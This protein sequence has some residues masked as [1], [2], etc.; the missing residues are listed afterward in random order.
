MTNIALDLSQRAAATVAP[1]ERQIV[2]AGPGSG[3]TEVVSHLV[4]HLVEDLGV[5][6]AEGLVVLSFSNAAVFAADARLRARRAGPVDVQTVDSLAGEILRDLADTETPQLSFDRRIA[7]ATKLLAECDWDRLEAIEHLVVDEIQD[8]V[9]VRADFLL[10]VLG[11]LPAGAGFTLLGDPA[12]GIYDFQI[13]PDAKPLSTTTSAALLRRAEALGDVTVRHLTGQYRATSRD[14]TRLVALREAVL[15]AD[16]TGELDDFAADLVPLGSIADA[17]ARARRWS[18]TTVF[19]TATNGQAM[20]VA[21]EITAAGAM[22]EVRRSARQRVHASWIARLLADRPTSGVTREELE[23]LVAE[24]AQELE[25]ASLWRA[26]RSVAR[27]RGREVDLRALSAGLRRPRPLMPD[28]IDRP[29]LPLVVS[30]V[31]RAKGLEFDHVVHVDFPDKAWVDDATDPQTALRTRYVALSR[32]RHHIVRASGPDD[33][34]LRRFELHGMTT[35]RWYTG[36]YKP[37]MTFSYEFRVDDLDRG[38][39]P[40]EDAAAVQCHIAER[41]R[42]G[43]ELTLVLD[44]ARSTLTMPVWSLLHEGVVV[45]RTSEAFGGDLVARIGTL[46]RKRRGWPGLS[47]ARVESVVTVAGDPQPA[48]GRHGLWLSPVSAGLLRI[49]WNGDTDG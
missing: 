7:L 41:V 45:G 24:R 42:P 30:T 34:F 32:A 6:A 8:V 3:K 10:L 29:N 2:I 20:M 35:P 5:D 13:R 48:T 9:G 40:G 37:Y 43:D 1:S 38:E 11:R 46:E 36:G 44:R 47:G 16:P 28:L 25:A 23:E 49:D 27:G 15:R 21:A 14:A 19:L 22:A 12:Q 26:L 31:H 18:G 17:V 33:R 4:E 39:P